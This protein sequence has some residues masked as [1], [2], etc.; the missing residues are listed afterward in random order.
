MG[1]L[2]AARGIP[3]GQIIQLRLCEPDLRIRELPQALTPM[4]LLEMGDLAHRQIPHD[5]F[6]DCMDLWELSCGLLGPAETCKKKE[7]CEPSLLLSPRH[8]RQ[9]KLAVAGQ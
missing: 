8:C 7:T 2:A 1:E 6:V 9:G 5:H 3:F 4:R